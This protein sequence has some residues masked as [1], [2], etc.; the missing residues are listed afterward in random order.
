MIPRLFRTFFKQ[1]PQP[2]QRVARR[3]DLNVSRFEFE[4]P[5]L[6]FSSWGEGSGQA[7]RRRSGVAGN[8]PCKH[9]IDQLTSVS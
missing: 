3:Q 8:V 6:S 9:G 4:S 5:L 7:R 1:F 2:L